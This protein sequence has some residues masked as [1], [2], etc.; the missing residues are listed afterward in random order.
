MRFN[1]KILKNIYENKKIKIMKLSFQ[2]NSEGKRCKKK[3]KK[4]NE[5]SYL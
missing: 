5:I 2:L 3:V 4:S 1:F